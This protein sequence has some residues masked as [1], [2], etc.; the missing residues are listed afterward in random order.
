MTQ[1]DDVLD[2]S[3]EAEDG[4]ILRPE[5]SLLELLILKINARY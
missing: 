5:V 2:L 1:E 3:S 4:I